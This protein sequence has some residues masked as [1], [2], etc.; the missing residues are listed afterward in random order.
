[1]T[2]YTIITW[3]QGAATEDVYREA[4]MATTKHK[5]TPVFDIPPRRKKYAEPTQSYRLILKMA[6]TEQGFVSSKVAA[7]LLGVTQEALK[8]ELSRLVCRQFLVA[9]KDGQGRNAV[10][11]ATPQGR[12]LVEGFD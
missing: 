5:R 3:G 8:S 1:M 6:A 9:T 2:A 10:F 12:S 4:M 7:T 11:H